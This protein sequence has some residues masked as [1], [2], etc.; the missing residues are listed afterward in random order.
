MTITHH[1]IEILKIYKGEDLSPMDS[2]ELDGFARVIKDEA[3]ALEDSLDD[4][5]NYNA[6]TNESVE[7][8]DLKKLA[9]I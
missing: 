8:S 5:G 6:S 9:G 2:I 3:E 1:L 4:N 7:Q